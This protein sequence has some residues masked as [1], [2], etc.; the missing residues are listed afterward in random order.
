MGKALRG[1]LVALCACHLAAA[2]A[3]GQ[4]GRLAGETTITAGEPAW[5]SIRL[6][7]DVTFES[8]RP[9]VTMRSDAAWAGIA[10]R[11]V[12]PAESGH[13]P[14]LSWVRTSGSSGASF[15]EKLPAGE[16]R[17]IA[18]SAS[19]GPVSATLKL[20]GLAGVARVGATQPVPL[21]RVSLAP[22][23][24]SSA[25]NT[26]VIGGALAGQGLGRGGVFGFARVTYRQS[27]ANLRV[28]R[29]WATND[30]ALDPASYD[31]GCPGGSSDDQVPSPVGMPVVPAG[32][33]EGGSEIV[34]SG[35]QGFPVG[36]GLNVTT[37]G[38]AP[39]M[40]FETA[41]VQFADA[42]A[43]DVAPPPPPPATPAMPEPAVRRVVCPRRT[44]PLGRR[45]RAKALSLAGGRKRRV[46]RPGRSL[47][48]DCG[49]RVS[50]R[51]VVVRSTAGTYYVSRFK[52]GYRVWR[53]D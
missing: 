35:S 6:P 42:R 30:A 11:A 40:T 22:A 38:T 19:G 47:A 13:H 45:A 27:G 33:G 18:A 8:E 46:V 17:L 31:V 25:Q 52:R 48:R 1:T 43:P 29:C 21:H 26:W 50:R 16:Y 2:P 7:K 10:M 36:M 28:Q 39:E 32:E 41:F 34:F 4:D 53:Q 12:Q 14:M 37:T 20:P 9:S 3:I 15:S 24:S 5:T 23:P 44:L 51:T 49:R